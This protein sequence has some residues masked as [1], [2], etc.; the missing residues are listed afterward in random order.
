MIRDGDSQFGRWP[1]N[2]FN[3]NRHSLTDEEYSEL[4]NRIKSKLDKLTNNEI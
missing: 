4:V 3:A 1:R 2:E